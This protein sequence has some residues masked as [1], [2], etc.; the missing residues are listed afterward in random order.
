M[1]IVMVAQ[2]TERGEGG[3]GGD[4]AVAMVACRWRWRRRRWWWVLVLVI[5]VFIFVF[6]LIP[7]FLSLPLPSSSSLC[8]L[9]ALV[10]SYLLDHSCHCQ[11]CSVVLVLARVTWTAVVRALFV[12][13]LLTPPSHV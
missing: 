5:V 1:A 4:M 6:V 10:C 9:A 13:P 8:S 3:G 11:D 2:D 12:S 7:V